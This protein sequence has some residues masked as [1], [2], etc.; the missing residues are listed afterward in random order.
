MDIGYWAAYPFLQEL[1]QCLNSG[2][3]FF[4]LMEFVKN[5]KLSGAVPGLL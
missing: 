3:L 5:G 4:H 2:D 1:D